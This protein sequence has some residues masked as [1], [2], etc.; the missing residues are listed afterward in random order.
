MAFNS[1]TVGGT[2]TLQLAGGAAGETVTLTN[3]ISRQPG[4]TLIVQPTNATS[5]GTATEKLLAPTLANSNGIV[6]PWIVT[7][8]GVAS[9]ARA[10]M[11]SSPM[12]P[13]V[14]SRRPMAPPPSAPLPGPRWLIETASQTLSAN[15][16]AYALKVESGKT[17][18]LAGTNLVARRR[19]RVRPA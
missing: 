10:R 12:A 4:A 5:L 17:L 1:L 15:A 2:A 16:S 13:T 8:N 11:I 6:S 14:W 3:G 19:D 9:S 18:N 7:N